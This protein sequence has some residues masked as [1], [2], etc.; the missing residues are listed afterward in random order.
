MQQ[1]GQ[2]S[3]S[4]Y[5]KLAQHL[6]NSRLRRTPGH[7]RLREDG[8][9][10]PRTLE[11]LRNFQ[12][13]NHITN[14]RGVVGPLTWRALGLSVEVEHNVTLRPQHYDMGCWSAS[15]A[16]ILNRDMSIGTGGADL[17]L[18]FGLIPTIDNVE[19]FAAQFGWHVISPPGD[20]RA[21]A[22]LLSH[23][24]I[25]MAG[26]VTLDDGSQGGHVVVISGAWGDGA[27]YGTYI[28]VHDPWPVNHGAVGVCTY[29][30]MVAGDGYAFDPFM[31]AGAF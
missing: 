6:L 24:P 29:P 19:T 3:S 8:A 27:T 17:G 18:T 26:H 16:M 28:R 5:V 31:I 14:E 20:V 30:G 25:W 23:G 12:A 11:A 13:L 10:G 21:L 4:L 2:G 7:R 9:F 22:D 1:V 15:A